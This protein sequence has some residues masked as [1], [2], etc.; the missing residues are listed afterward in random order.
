MMNFKNKKGNIVFD[1]F[2]VMI[3]IVIFVFSITI[4]FK[5]WT[6]FNSK[7]QALPE[8]VASTQIKDTIGGFGDW[9]LFLDKILPFG[10]I[11][12]WIGVILLSIRTNPD[13]PAFFLIALIILLLFTAISF[14][15]V[16][17]GTNFT[18]NT[19]LISISEQLGNTYFFIH[20]LHLIS[21]FVMLASATWFWGKGALQTDEIGIR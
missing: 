7:I 16:D 5:I 12:M 20:N 15:I 17:V 4:S 11:A 13:H 2:L 21:F 8:S 3:I 19:L 1:I 14:I 6:E 18:D 9:F 10:F